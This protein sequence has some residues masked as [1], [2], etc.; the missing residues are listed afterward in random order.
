MDGEPSY[1]DVASK[2]FF[3][4]S[5]TGSDQAGKTGAQTFN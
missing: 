4:E 5:K 2:I 1:F 3:I